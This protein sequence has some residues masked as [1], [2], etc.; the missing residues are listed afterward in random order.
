MYL[1]V[2]FGGIILRL[3]IRDL[4][5]K[6]DDKIV[7]DGV[8]YTFEQG[9]IYGIAGSLKSGKSTL[10]NCISGESRCDD[11]YAHIIWEDGENSPT[12]EDVGVIYSNAILPGFMTGYEFVRYF[13]DLH[14]EFIEEDRTLEGY[15]RDY[16]ISEEEQQELLR[17]YT[18]EQKNRL[19]MLCIN[20]VQPPVILMDEPVG[21][22]DA[23]AVK[24]LRGQLDSMKEDHIIIFASRNARTALELSDELVLL[25]EGHLKGI[26]NEEKNSERF[27]IELTDMLTVVE[28]ENA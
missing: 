22:Y 28:E 4:V 21:V 9:R 5:K 11:G 12:V 14:R 18:P 26:S 13:M 16:N 19:Q 7:L 2:K 10:F 24:E 23:K 1:R 25:D 8:G 15:L 17:D 6:Y 3:V 20:I 27:R